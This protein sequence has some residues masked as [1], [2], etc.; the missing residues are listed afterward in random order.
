M[1][2]T[3]TRENQLDARG[4]DGDGYA[5]RSQNYPPTNTPRAERGE[6]PR[7]RD[8]RPG[9]K[10]ARQVSPQGQEAQ[11][12]EVGGSGPASVGLTRTPLFTA[13]HADRYARQ[14][15]IDRYEQLTGVSLIAI[16]D[17]IFPANLTYI[18]E[19]L[20]DLDGSKPLHVLLASPGG[21]GETAIRITRVLQ[22]R[23]TEL[24]VIVPDLAKSAATLICLGADRILMGPAGD[25]GPVD[26]QL[27]LGQRRLTGA[28]EII[29]A[30]EHAEERV[31]AAGTNTEVMGLYA[32]LLEG[33]DMVIVQEA[34]SASA[35]DEALILEALGCS[36]TRTAS[37]A[38][39][40]A[41]KLNKPLITEAKSHGAVF[42]GEQA[43]KIGLPV[44]IAEPRSEQWRLVWELWTR[45]FAMECFP[46]GFTAVYEGR[47]ASQVLFLD[48]H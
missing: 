19:L 27:Q 16:I 20:H 43:Q 33:V 21:D 17:Q 3:F 22:S 9:R 12:T 15:I 13:R 44:I 40:M 18:E 14:E 28:R 4:G 6:P 10:A 46:A 31:R 2:T 32:A 30:V 39:G 23:C 48:P 37:A 1:D 7:Q 24:T 29:A 5:G 11:P 34:R 45:Y 8:P 36:S 47:R 35:R 41:K 42:S 38:R 25:L 26:A